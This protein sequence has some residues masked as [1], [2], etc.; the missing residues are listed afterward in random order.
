MTRLAQTLFLLALLM[1][2]AC[3]QTDE[4]K[5]E[6]I[7]REYMSH[8]IGASA[9][10]RAHIETHAS[11]AGWQVIFHDAYA[12]S[13]EGPFWPDA[14]GW[15]GSDC[16]FR[17]VYA[18]ID[19]D[20]MIRQVAGSPATA[21]FEAKDVACPPMPPLAPAPTLAGRRPSPKMLMPTAARVP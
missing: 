9:V 7:A 12:S 11:A 2:A 15:G 10:S 13:D 21:S 1:L 14:C 17:E 18:C 6:Q 3:R 5:A 8:T 4:Q 16:V 20:W 19:G